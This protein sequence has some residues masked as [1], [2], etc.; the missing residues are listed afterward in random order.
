MTNHEDVNYHWGYRNCTPTLDC[1]TSKPWGRRKSMYCFKSQSASSNT[2]NRLPEWLTNTLRS[3]V[4]TTPKHHTQTQTH[5]N[6]PK[7]NGIHDTST[8]LTIFG[9]LISFKTLISRSA[10]A[11][12]P[13]VQASILIRFRAT[14]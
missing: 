4:R 3:L 13:S 5:K 12:T 8:D 6:H 2:K 14:C 7:H 1:M 11:G 9:W 10:V